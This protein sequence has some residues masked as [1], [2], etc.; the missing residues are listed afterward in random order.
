MW[1]GDLVTMRWWDGLWLNETFATYM[2]NLANVEATRFKNSWTTFAMSYKAKAKAQDQLPTTHPIVAEIP[3]VESVLLNFDPITYEK[4]GAA[5]KQ[6][7]AWVG[8]E[9][10]FKGVATY[11]KRHEYGNTELSDFLVR[12]FRPEYKVAF[13]AWLTTDPFH[14][15]T[16]PPGPAFMPQYRNASAAEA[17]RLDQEAN[18]AFDAGNHS[19][20]IGDEYVRVT[21]LLAVVL[22]LTALSQRFDIRK[23]RLGIIGTAFVVLVYSIFALATVGT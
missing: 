16:A 18:R 9:A 20:E 8:E 1:F 6:L 3:D 17:T 11:F 23:V 14:N 13:D 5:L 2:G 15:A 21:V 7:V 12:R 22:F 4:G 19:R 10:F